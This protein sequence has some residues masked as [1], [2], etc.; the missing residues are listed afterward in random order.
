MISAFA[1]TEAEAGSDP[2]NMS[3]TATP[4]PPKG[5]RRKVS[6]KSSPKEDTASSSIVELSLAD[7]SSN[8]FFNNK[9]EHLDFLRKII[10]MS[11]R[12]LKKLDES[13]ALTI[14]DIIK[15]YLSVLS[16]TPDFEVFFAA[17][18]EIEEWFKI[19]RKENI[20]AIILF[21]SLYRKSPGAMSFSD[22]SYVIDEEHA[23]TS[24]S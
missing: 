1:L 4:T 3:T 20:P 15:P 23:T 11:P 22:F 21:L 13:Q 8:E 6:S 2:R 12:E 16:D 9:L 10:G 7:L 5:E 14:E 19:K 17:F 18:S 24:V